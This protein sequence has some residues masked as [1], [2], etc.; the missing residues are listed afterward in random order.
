MHEGTLRDIASQ[1]SP[2]Q[3]PRLATGKTKKEA[4]TGVAF[5]KLLGLLGEPPDELAKKAW[6]QPHD[7]E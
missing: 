1:S 7:S 3:Q 2:Q 5:G 6:G 4:A